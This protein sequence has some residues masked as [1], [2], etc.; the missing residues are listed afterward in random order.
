ME[1]LIPY[2]LHA[3]KKDKPK[4]YYR[5]YS[6]T[7]NRSYHR[8]SSESIHNN[9]A[10]GSSHRRTR[11]EFQP[12]PA[13]DFLEQRSHSYNNRGFP[14]PASM[15]GTSDRNVAVDDSKGSYPSFQTYNMG[16]DGSSGMRR[17][18]INHVSK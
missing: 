12:P 18:K 14:S 11:S 5:S 4:N 13:L 2:L 10:E 3:L 1:G 15:A 9:L 8:L 16:V 6:D 17:K 7:S